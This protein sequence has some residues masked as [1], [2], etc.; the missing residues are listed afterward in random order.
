MLRKLIQ[1]T[2]NENQSATL[3]IKTRHPVHNHALAGTADLVLSTW[4][5]TG[6]SYV[7]T[8]PIWAH[9]FQSA[10]GGPGPKRAFS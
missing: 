10:S 3:G 7:G 1:K 9:G 2:N 6:R 8:L 5:S 4:F